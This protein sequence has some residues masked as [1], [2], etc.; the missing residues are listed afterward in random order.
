M[1]LLGSIETA[2][3]TPIK[4]MRELSVGDGLKQAVKADTLSLSAWQIG[5]YGWMALPSFVIFG[6]ELPKGD[7]TFWFMQIAMFAGFAVSYPVQL[8]AHQER[9]FKEKM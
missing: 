9:H 1:K 3:T 7:P 4:P 2:C 8:V 6:H 5:M